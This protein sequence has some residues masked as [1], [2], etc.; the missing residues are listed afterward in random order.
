MNLCENGNHP[1]TSKDPK[2]RFCSRSCAATVNNRL[3]PKRSAES[4]PCQGECGTMIK[5]KNRKYCSNKCQMT[6]RSNDTIE[7]WLQTGDRIPNQAKRWILEEQSNQCAICEME[8]IWNEKPIV[9]I[10]DHIDG[11]STNNSRTNLR[12]VCP[13]CDSQLETYKAKNKG[14]GRFHRRQRYAEGKSY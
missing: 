10:L 12:V 8:P 5:G 3:T 13:N 14:K 11:D 1:F 9:F 4:K 6:K 7:H 2:Q